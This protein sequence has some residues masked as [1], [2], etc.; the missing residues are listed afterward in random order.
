MLSLRS[1]SVHNGFVASPL[2][3]VRRVSRSPA[4]AMH[5]S[6]KVDKTLDY[7][8]EQVLT[9]IVSSHV[10]EIQHMLRG[11]RPASLL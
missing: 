3:G 9:F 6:E 10:G 7:S 8:Q 2:V 11:E 5:A 1:T 4:V